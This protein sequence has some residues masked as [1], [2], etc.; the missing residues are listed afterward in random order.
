[1]TAMLQ[2]TGR[3]FIVSR[4]SAS[5]EWIKQQGYEH[6]EVIHHFAATQLQRGDL[7]IGT[8]PVHLAR[9]INEQGIRFIYFSIN[10][11]ESMR[12]KEISAGL[13]STLNP[14]LEELQVSACH[15][16]PVEI[17]QSETLLHRL[18]DCFRSHDRHIMIF[19][20][21]CLLFVIFLYLG[22]WAA[23]NT[24]NLPL[25]NDVD[26]NGNPKTV[27]VILD[28]AGI[29]F[30]YVT[31]AFAA[32]ALLSIYFRF[33][34]SI[35]GPIKGKAV[36]MDQLTSKYKAGMVLATQ[37][38]NKLPYWLLNRIALGQKRLTL[39]VLYTDQTRE[40]AIKMIDT[41]A[42]EIDFCMQPSDSDQDRLLQPLNYQANRE[43]ARR[44]I[45]KFLEQV[46]ARAEETFIDITGGTVVMSVS[47]MEAAK[48]RGMNVLY[49]SS[50]EMVTEK[51]YRLKEVASTIDLSPES[52]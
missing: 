31:V 45:D 47:M 44:M 50:R 18:A 19:G 32:P 13:L 37:E 11:P 1:M 42:G 17:R 2:N 14:R 51:N 34:R 38:R 24:V 40:S 52:L 12:G 6:A 26:V 30:S 4:H 48:E 27:A 39:A 25:I 3:T 20:L 23:N 9:E 28:Q 49:T 22:E 33:K 43:V 29:V 7:V 8:L 16:Q 15:H 21:G 35:K 10:V 5:I 36:N 41:F 46:N